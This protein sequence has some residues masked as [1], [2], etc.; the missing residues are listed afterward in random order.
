[1]IIRESVYAGNPSMHSSLFI[2]FEEDLYGNP[3][4]G[5]WNF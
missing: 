1:M 3:E 2:F 4:S 5:S